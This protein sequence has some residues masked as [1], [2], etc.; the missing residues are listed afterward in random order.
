MRFVVTF[1]TNAAAAVGDTLAGSFHFVPVEPVGGTTG[2]C[3]V[4]GSARLSTAAPILSWVRDSTEPGYQRSSSS[5][6]SSIAI[7]GTGE[8]HVFVVV[9]P[10]QD[11]IGTWEYFVPASN[12]GVGGTV[13]YDAPF[14]R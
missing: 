13:L 11:S 1:V 12:S 3:A 5:Q 10:V 2:P 9:L 4:A 14:L 8:G 6:P 7:V